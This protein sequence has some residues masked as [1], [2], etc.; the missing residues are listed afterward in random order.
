MRFHRTLP[1]IVAA[2]ALTV[3]AAPAASS[4]ATPKYPTVS[5]VSPLKAG[6]GN[7]LTIRGKGFRT[8]KG[9]NTVVFRSA[10]GGRTVFVKA[11]N[12]SSTRISV[13]IPAKLLA[14]MS[15]K[16]G[17]AAPTK[18]QIRIVAKRLGKKYTSKAKSPTIGPTA[19]ANA[20]SDDCDGDGVKNSN[21]GDDDN[22][23][24]P[25]SREVSLKTNSCLA[26]T[27]GDGITDGYEYYSALDYNGIGEPYP[28]R[29]PYPNPLDGTDG[30]I[31]H[32]GDSLTLFEEYAAWR[33]TGSPFPLSY[34]AGTQFTG[35]K[36]PI[37]SAGAYGSGTHDLPVLGL[38]DGFI[39]DHEKDVDNDGIDNFAE[40]HGPMSSPS[41]WTDIY[42]NPSSNEC[43][44]Q[45]SAYPLS[46]FQGTNFLDPDSDGD[47]VRDGP[48]D[49]DH[50]GY[51]NRFETY[52]PGVYNTPGTLWCTTYVST[53]HP[54][55]NPNP[56]A[57]VQPFN[58]CKPTYSDMC[59][60]VVPAGY[61][62]A[63][64]DWASPHFGVWP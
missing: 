61:Y 11:G 54:G 7:T 36:A 49:V 50:D 35:G 25:D 9:K 29:R 28:G 38:P 13:V 62:Q 20:T 16:N 64:E 21:D 55:T 34:S 37:A 39:A 58:P 32:D 42:G 15:S 2:L 24:L 48:D 51:S 30:N 6:I 52:R 18:F 59:H 10:Q 1:P 44:A 33:V 17:A 63:G 45:E 43:G 23:L 5:K 31:D 22:D 40:A 53:T 47:G 4:A 46:Q 14:Y 8:G 60:Q 26:D 57:R 3:V 27:D 19:V 56:A 41:W 12:A